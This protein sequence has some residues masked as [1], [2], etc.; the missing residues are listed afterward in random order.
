MA[1]PVKP[2]HPPPKTGCQ[3]VPISL[4]CR[5]VSVGIHTGIT[6]IARIYCMLMHTLRQQTKRISKVDGEIRKYGN[7]TYTTRLTQKSG[8]LSRS[9]PY[10]KEG[11][12][13]PSWPLGM[14]LARRL[15]R[16]GT[17]TRRRNGKEAA[18]YSPALHCSTIGA[19]GLNFSVRNGKR[20][21]PAAIAT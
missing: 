3:L 20:W 7:S 6:P 5:T 17:A 10:K 1:P 11:C 15:R 19:G 13:P 9:V 12:R 21:D 16:G 14:A 4:H 8:L 18:S 2:Y